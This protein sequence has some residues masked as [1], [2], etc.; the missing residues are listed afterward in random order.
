MGLMQSMRISASALM[1]QRLRMDVVANN[2]ANM[3]TSRTV[4]G[5]PYRRQSVVFAEQSREVPF[6]DFLSRES[7]TPGTGGG[8]KVTEIREDNTPPRRVFDPQHPDADPDGYVLLPDINVVTELTDLVSARRAYEASVT[9]LNA[10]KSMAL[11]A[12]EIGRG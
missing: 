9:V 5:G 7:G 8:V 3:N 4:G 1:A 6:R 12:L 11:R 2:V 10:T